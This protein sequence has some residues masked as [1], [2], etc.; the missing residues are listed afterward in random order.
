MKIHLIKKQTIQRF[1]DSHASGKSAFENWVTA[2]K[3]ADWLTSS[4]IQLT[5]RTADILGKGSN[6]VVFNIGG[7][8]YRLIGQYHFGA[9]YV[10]LFICWVGTHAQYDELCKLGQ[11]FTVNEY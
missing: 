2:I 5:F 6:R 10:H 8:N 11:Q 1:A 4:D 3:Y 7:N 9:T